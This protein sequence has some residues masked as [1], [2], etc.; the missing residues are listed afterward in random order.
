MI[1]NSTQNFFCN[2]EPGMVETGTKILWNGLMSDF[3]NDSRVIRFSPLYDGS[4]GIPYSESGY[5]NF[6]CTNRGGTA[7]NYRPLYTHPLCI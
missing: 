4:E 2:R 5:N 1:K 3:L 6:A 7:V